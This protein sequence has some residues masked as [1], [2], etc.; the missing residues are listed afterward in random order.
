MT[1][2]YNLYTSRIVTQD[3]NVSNH[4]TDKEECSSTTGVSTI[5]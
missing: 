4:T 5:D 2:T 3:V 1:S